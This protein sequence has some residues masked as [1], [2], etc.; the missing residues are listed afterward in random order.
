MEKKLSNNL[1]LKVLSVFLAFFVWLAVVNINNPE[2]S[3]SKEVPL[4][5]VNDGILTAN[6]KTYEL[7]TDKD[8]VTVSYRVRTLDKAGISASD[9]RA[10]IDL[11]E[12]YEPTGAVPVKVEVKGNKRLLDDPV[13][14]PGVIRIKTEDLQRKPFNLTA[15]TEGKVAEGYIYGTP[16]IS[17]SYIYVSGPMSLVGQINSVGIMIKLDGQDADL[18]G[19]EEV[20]CFDANGVVLELGDRVTFSRTEIEY[21]V[22]I[23]KV[24]GL[25]LNFEPEGRVAEGYRYTGIESSLNSVEVVG[26]KS[27]LASIN[28]LTIPGSEL[29]MDGATGDREVTVDLNQYLPEGITLADPSIGE[30]KVVIKVEAL[31]DRTF[32]LKTSQIKQVGAYSEYDYQYDR[33]SVRVVI[34]GLKEDLDQLTIGALEAELNVGNMVPGVNDGEITIQLGDAY[35]LVSYDYIQVT[36]SEKGPSGESKAAGEDE[37]G[38]ETEDETSEGPSGT[39]AAETKAETKAEAD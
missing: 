39:T 36:V 15:N 34:R 7:L 20:K 16:V 31:E 21:T 35:E 24:K 30:I 32:E 17:P 13:A 10:Y 6:G 3:D 27:N 25:V 1:G 5:I 8:T 11:A 9:F 14:R 26:L 37:S 18:S 38:S 4:E 12:V 33:D 22:P 19:T 29:N 28:S 2:D 23:L